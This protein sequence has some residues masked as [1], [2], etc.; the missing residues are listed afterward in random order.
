M[1]LPTPKPYGLSAHELY[2]IYFCVLQEK[3]AGAP[4]GKEAL[5]SGEAPKKRGF[6][7]SA[8]SSAGP[9]D[10][11][12]PEQK[13]GVRTDPDIAPPKMDDDRQQTPSSKKTNEL[14]C[15]MLI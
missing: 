15:C 4:S 13:K 2:Y 9:A 11:D 10:G 8:W 7:T 1:C 14:V 3:G 6:F 5:K 12:S